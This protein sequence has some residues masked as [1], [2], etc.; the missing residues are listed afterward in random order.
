MSM[1]FFTFIATKK[2]VKHEIHHSVDVSISYLGKSL[3]EDEEARQR[4]YE[5]VEFI[6]KSGSYVK[7]FNHAMVE[8]TVETAS[9][10]KG[11]GAFMTKLNKFLVVEDIEA[12]FLRY[13]KGL[14]YYFSMKAIEKAG[15]G[16]DI[17]IDYDTFDKAV[18]AWL[19]AEF[20]A[21]VTGLKNTIADQLCKFFNPCVF[22]LFL[23]FLFGG[24]FALILP[25]VHF[26]I[27]KQVN[28]NTESNTSDLSS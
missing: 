19:N 13:E 12:E 7:D 2:V 3:V 21:E 10:Q 1:T 16:D 24:F 5:N 4:M 22:S 14:D 15:L 28:R 6:L 27:A 25:V 17:G 8:A 9:K 18:D 11:Y 23:P 20:D 26:L